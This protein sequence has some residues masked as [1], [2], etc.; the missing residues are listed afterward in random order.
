MFKY[1]KIVKFYKKNLYNYIN[2]KPVSQKIKIN[3]VNIIINIVWK[4]KV[5]I[6]NLDKISKD[7]PI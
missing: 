3:I 4:V 6:L 2:N 7:F 5:K 1:K